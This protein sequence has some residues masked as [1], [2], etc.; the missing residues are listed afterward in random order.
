MSWSAARPWRTGC[1]ALVA[2]PADV[3]AAEIVDDGDEA[4]ESHPSRSTHA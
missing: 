3:D 2:E 4:V 1:R